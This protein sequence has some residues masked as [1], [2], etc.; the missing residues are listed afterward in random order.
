FGLPVKDM[1]GLITYCYARGV[2]CSK[3]IASLLRQEPTLSDALGRALPDEETIRRFRR[4]YSAAIEETLKS[5]YRR[6]P[7]AGSPAGSGSGLGD[8]EIARRHAAEILHEA[9]RTDNSK[10]R[11]G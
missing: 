6:F 4:R 5:L 2:F 11:V 1:L 10:G 7:F 9:A 3:D 8:T